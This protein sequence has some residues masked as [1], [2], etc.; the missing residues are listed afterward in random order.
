[1]FCFIHR[2]DVCKT[3]AM[4]AK[5]GEYQGML[6]LYRQ[7]A[8]QGYMVFTKGFVPAFVRLGP[9]TIL[10]WLFLEQLRLNFGTIV[11]S[12]PTI[13]RTSSSR[14]DKLILLESKG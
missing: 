6:D 10:T 12:T 3:L 8:R 13:E 2:I 11:H 7:T 4:N 14:P 9:Q 5:T 1:M